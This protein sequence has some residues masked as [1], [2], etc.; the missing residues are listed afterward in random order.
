MEIENLDSYFLDL[1]IPE[2]SYPY[3][4]D[5]VAEELST[6]ISRVLNLSLESI[7]LEKASS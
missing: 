4:K 6:Y 5:E 2:N 1:F 3:S 7:T